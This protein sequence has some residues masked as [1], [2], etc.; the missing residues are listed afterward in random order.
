MAKM[1]FKQRHK[2][3]GTIHRKEKIIDKYEL[4][5]IGETRCA[6]NAK[7]HLHQWRTYKTSAVLVMPNP[8]EL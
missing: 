1:R 7:N 2:Q 4:L 6:V 8:V 3:T 5:K